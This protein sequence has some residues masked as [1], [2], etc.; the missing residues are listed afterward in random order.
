MSVTRQSRIDRMRRSFLAAYTCVTTWIMLKQCGLSAIQASCINGIISCVTC[1]QLPYT[2]ASFCGTFAGMSTHPSSVIEVSMLGI[3]CGFVYYGFESYR[4]FVG[5]G[6]RLGT[7]AFFSNILYM[8]IQSPKRSVYALQSAVNA[9]HPYSVLLF[10]F[11][12]SMLRYTK[13]S[14]KARSSDFSYLTYQ[15]SMD[16]P[17]NLQQ[18]CKIIA[19]VL[20]VWRVLLVSRATFPALELIQTTLVV[21]IASISA[22]KIPGLVLPA[23]VLGL[24]GS[25]LFPAFAAQIYLGTFIGMTSLPGYASMNLVQSSLCSTCLLHLG[26]FDGFGGKLGLLALLGVSVCR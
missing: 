25:I 12:W 18:I 2:A 7:I 24:L 11:M 21:A 9:I 6:G 14:T 16:T 5:F 3:V 10:A 13:S 4:S 23:A 26:I 19:L 15:S 8:I 17:S 1:T 22:K 20:L